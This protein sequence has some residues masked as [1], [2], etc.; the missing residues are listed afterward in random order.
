MKRELISAE[1]GKLAAGAISCGVGLSV[2]HEAGSA[3]PATSADVL[4]SQSQGRVPR[5]KLY[6][7]NMFKISLNIIMTVL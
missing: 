2:K 5:S 3:V 6:V 7:F 4:S 1:T